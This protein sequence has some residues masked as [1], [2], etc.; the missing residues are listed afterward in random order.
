MVFFDMAFIYT[1]GDPVPRR[2]V[3]FLRSGVD[4]RRI[5]RDIINIYRFD[6]LIG[7]IFNK[8]PLFSTL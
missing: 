6:F 7:V 8:M 2:V 4:N 1:L 3:P 5:G